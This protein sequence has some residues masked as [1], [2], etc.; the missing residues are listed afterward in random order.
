MSK[1]DLF[2]QNPILNHLVEPSFQGINRIFVLAFE[3]DAERTNNKRYCLR[4]VEIKNF[5][6]IIDGKLFFDQR[7]KNDEITY[8]NIRKIATGYGYDHTTAFLLACT[9]FNDYYK[10]IVTDL[11]KY[12][13]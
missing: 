13:H 10:M 2:A 6:V 9:Y 4:S 11:S 8:E 5:N 3:N 1:P 12:K 7:V